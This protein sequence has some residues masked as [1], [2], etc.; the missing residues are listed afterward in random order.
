[1]RR[2]I[3]P[4]RN[5]NLGEG[6]GGEM[7]TNPTP[8][9]LLTHPRGNVVI[10]GGNAPEVAVDATQHWGKITE[11]STVEM[12]PEEAVLPRS[13]GTASTPPTCAGSCRRTCTST[14]PAR[15]P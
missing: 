1:M 2:T 14:T 13:S 4:L 9:Y 6:A 7:I 5:I 15:S 10:D 11:V 8:W 3:I 12:T